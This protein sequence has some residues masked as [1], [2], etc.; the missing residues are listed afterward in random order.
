V[1]LPIWVIE[2]VAR[3]VVLNR[4]KREPDKLVDDLLERPTIPAGGGQSAASVLSDPTRRRDAKLRTLGRSQRAASILPDYLAPNLRL[5]FYGTVVANRS[6]DVGHY[7]AG[8]G[9][10]FWEKL[11]DDEERK[12]AIAF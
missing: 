9:N 11:S 6:A 2:R 7:Y 5:V 12:E 3:R 10:E 8:N 4:E 1:C